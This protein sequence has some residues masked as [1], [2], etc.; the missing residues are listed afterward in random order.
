[1]S[2]KRQ[3]YK[4]RTVEP[5]NRYSLAITQRI[6]LMSEGPLFYCLW[7]AFFVP[8]C[9]SATSVNMQIV[10]LLLSHTLICFF[11]WYMMFCMIDR[12]NYTCVVY[13]WDPM[14]QASNEWI[15]QMGVHN[16]PKKQFQPFYNV[17]VED[18]SN[19]Y[20]AQGLFFKLTIILKTTPYSKFQ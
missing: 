12:Y 18:G 20:A 17:L 11:L 5:P 8:P 9:C 14:C 16:L 3:I 10:M 6:I 1:M 4:R 19:R 15:I 7:L 13:G 2:K